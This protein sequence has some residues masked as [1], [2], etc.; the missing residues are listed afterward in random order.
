MD[1]LKQQH[2]DYVSGLEAKYSFE[3]AEAA[4]EVASFAKIIEQHKGIP[5]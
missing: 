3:L 2:Q 1:L 5:R 4:Q